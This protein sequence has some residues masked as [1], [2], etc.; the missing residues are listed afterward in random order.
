MSR[1]FPAALHPLLGNIVLVLTLAGVGFRLLSF[2][3]RL[4]FAGHVAATL[5]IVAAF[6]APIAVSTGERAPERIELVSGLRAA[7]TTHEEAGRWAERFLF[8]IGSVEMLGITLFRDTTTQKKA[9]VVSAVIGVAA[10]AAVFAALRF[11]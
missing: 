4:T 1:F 8:V 9:N 10:V 2:K 6:A 11:M 7:V 5:L 3:A